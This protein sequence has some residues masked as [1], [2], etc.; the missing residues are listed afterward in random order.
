MKND[1]LAMYSTKR[2]VF[3]LNDSLKAYHRTV[4]VAYIFYD[5]NDEECFEVEDYED[6]DFINTE[7]LTTDDFLR[8]IMLAHSFTGKFNLDD[9]RCQF[10]GAGNFDIMDLEDTMFGIFS[11][12]NLDMYNFFVNFSKLFVG[13]TNIIIANY[14]EDIEQ[15]KKYFDKKEYRKIK[16][17]QKKRQEEFEEMEEEYMDEYYDDDYDEDDD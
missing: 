4:Y 12:S 1:E 6:I 3:E 9:T 2:K 5:E 16:N 7:I 8:N 17:F 11:Y 14:K 15:Q 10:I 13:I